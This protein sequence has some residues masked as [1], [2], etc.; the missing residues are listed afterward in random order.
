MSEVLKKEGNLSLLDWIISFFSSFY[1][2]FLQF[3][4]W[5]HWALN[6][7]L[8]FL[9]LLNW[10]KLLLP[11]ALLEVYSQ[12]TSGMLKQFFFQSGIP[13]LALS[14]V[15]NS[16]FSIWLIIK[17]FLQG[18]VCCVDNSTG[19]HLGHVAHHTPRYG[20]WHVHPRPSLF[21]SLHTWVCSGMIL[22]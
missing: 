4:H 19:G 16:H 8:R 6:P 11:M 17:N 22:S 15:L 2:L 12:T 14:H 10:K 20:C 21:C 18:A 7:S 3:G 9:T 13:T 1:F 5:Q